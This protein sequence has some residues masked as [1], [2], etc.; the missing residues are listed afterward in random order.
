LPPD[1]W[2]QSFTSALFFVSAQ[3]APWPGQQ[4]S[5]VVQ[6]PAAC[7][8]ALT[9]PDA[10]T[11]SDGSQQE[12]WPGQQQSPV[13]QQFEVSTAGGTSS[14]RTLPSD[15][16]MARAVPAPNKAKTRAAQAINFVCIFVL[17]EKG[18]LVKGTQDTAEAR[19]VPATIRG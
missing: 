3:H 16:P 9:A 18:R 1:T 5:P 11:L 7:R 2:Q 19:R 10:A 14:A 15:K 13:I 4:Q 8:D 17:Q 6:Q 12:P